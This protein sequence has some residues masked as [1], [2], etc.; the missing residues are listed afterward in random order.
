MRLVE[1][2]SE[3]DTLDVS[4]SY[5]IKESPIR[6]MIREASLNAFSSAGT[7]NSCLQNLKDDDDSYI[8]CVFDSHINFP[9]DK[10]IYK[11]RAY[12][13]N[14]IVALSNNKNIIQTKKS[15]LERKFSEIVMN[16]DITDIQ[17]ATAINAINLILNKVC[18]NDLVF[19]YSVEDEIVMVY[20]NERGNHY[21]IIG[22]ED[23]NDV[24]YGFVGKQIGQ[25]DTIHLDK[26]N[27]LDDLV[28]LFVNG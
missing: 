8:V 13:D 14:N 5:G 23:N 27:S 9:L 28:T 16:Y 21:L 18:L 12:I 19:K 1:V 2:L 26:D 22:D 4:P 24:S 15:E 11:Y 7:P 25:H 3:N 20:R 17:Y 6:K 10:D